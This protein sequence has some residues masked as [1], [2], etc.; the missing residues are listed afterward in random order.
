MLKFRNRII[1]QHKKKLN[2]NF[3]NKTI[4]VLNLSGKILNSSQKILN[5]TAKMVVSG[6]VLYICF[7]ILREPN[8]ISKDVLK[9]LYYISK[10]ILKDLC[11]KI[12]PKD[13]KDI[14]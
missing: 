11:L 12:H 10:N 8:Y 3:F 4:N 13:P 9:D 5:S 6:G 14:N 1:F 7:K 2:S